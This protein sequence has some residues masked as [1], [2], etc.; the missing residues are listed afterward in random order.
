VLRKKDPA[1]PAY[2]APGYPV[3]PILFLVLICVL[4][5]LLAA[6]N[7][8]QAFIGVGVVITGAIVYRLSFHK[9]RSDL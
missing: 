2:R 5:F 1:A 8:A 7:P 9:N 6:N 3:T 4:L